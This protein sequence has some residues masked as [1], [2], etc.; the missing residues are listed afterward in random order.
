MD[1]FKQHEGYIATDINEK[2]LK[3]DK[4]LA[5]LPVVI[6]CQPIGGSF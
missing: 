2:G 4:V 5:V 6:S 3:R 1:V